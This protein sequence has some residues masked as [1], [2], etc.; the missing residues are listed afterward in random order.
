MGIVRE[1]AMMLLCCSLLVLGSN[2]T[3]FA[4]ERVI[5]LNDGWQIKVLPYFV[6]VNAPGIVSLKGEVI[7]D[8]TAW[9]ERCLKFENSSYQWAMT[10][11]WKGADFQSW[12]P[13]P[14][15][16]FTL[17]ARLKVRHKNNSPQGIAFTCGV[18]GPGRQ[19]RIERTVMAKDTKNM[20]WQV[21]EVARF[22]P[23]NQT[24]YIGPTNNSDIPEIYI[25][26][27]YLV[28]AG[29][30]NL[31]W[32]AQDVTKP[33]VLDFSWKQKSDNSY[34]KA[35]ER[36]TLLLEKQKL[37]LGFGT[38]LLER[39]AIVVPKE[40]QKKGFVLL[41]TD[42]F[43]GIA[44]LN[45]VALKQVAEG[46]YYIPS[47]VIR[48]GM[49]NQLSLKAYVEREMPIGFAELELA[50]PHY[51]LPY[52]TEAVRSQEKGKFK[53]SAYIENS[54]IKRQ[55]FSRVD[56][57]ISEKGLINPYLLLSI[58]FDGMDFPL[59]FDKQRNCYSTLVYG[60]TPGVNSLLLC[61]QEDPNNITRVS[62]GKISVEQLFE[63]KVDIFPLG[64]YYRSMD[65]R[66]FAKT[67]QEINRHLGNV[68]L[69]MKAHGI[70][71]IA[72]ANF[73]LEK[74]KEFTVLLKAAEEQD[75]K[76]LL[77]TIDGFCGFSISDRQNIYKRVKEGVE[78][79]G[80]YSSL[81]GYNLA[82]EIN[83]CRAENWKYAKDIVERID[84]KRPVI[85]W[86]NKYD[87]RFT[88]R[89]RPA[90]YARD[91]YG[92]HGVTP[93]G[94]FLYELEEFLEK[95]VVIAETYD[96]PFWVCLQAYGPWGDSFMRMPSPKEML[97]QSWLAVAY[98]AKGL[99][100][101]T[102]YSSSPKHQALINGSEQ[103]PVPAYEELGRFLKKIRLITP[104]LLKLKSCRN[105]GY[106]LDPEITMTMRED[107]IGKR[108]IFL[109]NK[110]INTEK[111]V[112]FKLN[113][114]VVLNDIISGEELPVDGN[115]MF[116]C[117]IG[118]GEG[119]V[120]SLTM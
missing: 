9:D 59:E 2:S 22:L 89:M 64:I 97:A 110:N 69:D 72:A 42:K 27:F 77:H 44:Y 53:I 104:M 95:D 12:D 45:G 111:K 79:V 3:I 73:G 30:K 54:K 1:M 112:I 40:W 76:V 57:A 19:N 113:D 36:R 81:L 80:G 71:T 33:L 17:Y 62:I 90:V 20:Q 39:G 10:Y 99:F 108:Y 66:R 70:N 4:E 63:T 23:G 56:V 61:L 16:L 31:L 48:Y 93:P 94:Q 50:T 96:I 91:I 41:K 83:L 65:L 34:K 84:G 14:W 29:S 28:E 92:W 7:D 51:N 37:P 43:S 107:R 101:F 117:L 119:R 85:C 114:A 47:S 11:N 116:G 118:P 5:N 32:F 102:Y 78:K 115:G 35:T 38:I 8:K 67:E 24:F 74:E 98:G 87:S 86:L 88:E 103:A 106:C 46:R 58:Q 18:F 49:N 25:D 109:V 13:H 55:E 6:D 26:S 82:D 52:W 68:M 75:M 15:K 120:L 21:Y 105:T 60:K 100:Y